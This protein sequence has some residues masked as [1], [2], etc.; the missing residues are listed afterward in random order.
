M[1]ERYA[2]SLQVA[3]LESA[4]STAPSRKANLSRASKRKTVIT[5]AS[6]DS[7]S[8]AFGNIAVDNTVEEEKPSSGDEANENRET[9]PESFEDESTDSEEAAVSLQPARR[10]EGKHPVASSSPQ[11]PAP[12]HLPFTKRPP[13]RQIRATSKPTLRPD[14]DLDDD[15]TDD[16]EL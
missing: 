5:S 6:S 13:E 2:N 9:T 15:E 14:L 4:R 10:G 12:Q 8:D 1:L 3:Q 16:D 7:G 11:L